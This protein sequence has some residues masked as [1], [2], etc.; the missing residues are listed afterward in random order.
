M[1]T[2]S[3]KRT[4]LV[5]SQEAATRGKPSRTPPSVQATERPIERRNSCS[6]N[7]MKRKKLLKWTMP[8]MSVSQNSTRREVRNGAGIGKTS[9]LFIH[10]TL[11]HFDRV[12]G[13]HLGTES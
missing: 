7:S 4:G 13:H 11:V 12:A 9:K 2:M 5:K 3:S 8:A 6:A 1:S 10:H